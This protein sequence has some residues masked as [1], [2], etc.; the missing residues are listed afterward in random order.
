MAIC[1]FL[2]NVEHDLSILSGVFCGLTI[3]LD[4]SSFPLPQVKTYLTTLKLQCES[5]VKYNSSTDY[6][7][8]FIKVTLIDV[9]KQ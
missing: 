7:Y 2:V 6:L 8:S 4:L 1:H 9:H 3:Q 5:R